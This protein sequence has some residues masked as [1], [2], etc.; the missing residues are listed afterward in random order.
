MS[1][2]VDYRE[3]LAQL[4]REMNQAEAKRHVEHL[5]GLL[6]AQNERRDPLTGLMGIRWLQR[7]KGHAR[8]EAEATPDM[9]NPY[10]FLS[11]GVLFTMVD[12]SMGSALAGLL[13]EDERSATIEIKL[14]FLA[15]VNSGRVSADTTVAHA[16]RA[17]VYLE[18]KVK[19]DD[20]RLVVAATGSFYRFRVGAGR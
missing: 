16:G 5:S 3:R 7:E 14:N 9:L 11:G 1:E 10:G 12:Y 8:C 19:R 18:S 6:S 2:A 17:I 15:G 4:A 13:E 20:G